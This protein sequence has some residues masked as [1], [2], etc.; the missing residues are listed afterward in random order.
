MTSQSWHGQWWIATDAAETVPGT[1]TITEAGEIELQL[2]GGF[3]TLTSRDNQGSKLPRNTSISLIHGQCESTKITLL[4]SYA[5]RTEGSPRRP[6]RQIFKALRALVG[7]HIHNREEPVFKSAQFAF[8]NLT[9]FLQRYSF[10]RNSSTNG[11]PESVTFTTPETLNVSADGWHISVTTGFSG[12]QSEE[13]RGSVA[14]SGESTDYIRVEQGTPETVEGFDDIA[15]ALMDLLTLAS[16]EACGVISTSLVLVKPRVHPGDDDGEPFYYP[17]VVQLFGQHTHT[18]R[19]LDSPQQSLRFRFSCKDMTFN[20]IV[21]AWIPL[22]KRILKAADVLFGLDYIRAGFTETRLLSTAI[23]AESLHATLYPEMTP[24]T[25]EKF[26]DLRQKVLDAIDDPSEKTWVKA[27]LHNQA[28]FK[29]RI[30]D[31]ATKPDADAVDLIILDR[32]EWAKDLTDVRNGLAHTG[33]GSEASYDMFDLVQVTTFLIALV[34]MAALGLSAE[35][36]I[37][38]VKRNEYLSKIRLVTRPGKTE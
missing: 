14:I 32:N 28:S 12:F 30:L 20:E 7:T 6:T 2:I 21:S 37:E 33:A 18:A 36:Q 15:K 26:T 16:G 3:D 9:T 24:M 29:E 1:L 13:K 34:M 19:P 35:T 5:S 17:D 10:E 8:E 25:V 23:A 11:E 38:A 4:D 31:L 22:R 27:R